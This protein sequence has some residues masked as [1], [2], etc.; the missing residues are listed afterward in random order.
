M[1]L[2]RTIHFPT[3]SR[4]TWESVRSA[5]QTLA[6]VPIVRMIDNLPAFPDEIP[7]AGW[8]ELRI[9]L[10]GG[11]VTIRASS[12]GWDCV[13]WGN[14]DPLLTRSW[15]TTCWAIATAGQGR[16]MLEDGNSLTAEEFRTRA[17]DAP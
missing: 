4:P 8:R 11:M 15:D 1:G 6:E 5:F 9:G 7:E 2:Q 17:F 13:I 3:D 12:A 14:A 10:S 16:V